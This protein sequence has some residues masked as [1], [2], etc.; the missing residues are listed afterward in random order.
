VLFVVTRVTAGPRVLREV[1]TACEGDEA[2]RK[3]KYICPGSGVMSSQT[4]GDNLV[5]QAFGL[6]E[7]ATIDDT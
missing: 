2:M 4:H 5:P 6:D 3:E 7:Q 1:E